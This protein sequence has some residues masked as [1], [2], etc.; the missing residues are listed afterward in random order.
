MQKDLDAWGH[1]FDNAL[2][3]CGY[4]KQERFPMKRLV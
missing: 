1:K 4:H 2:S 3:H